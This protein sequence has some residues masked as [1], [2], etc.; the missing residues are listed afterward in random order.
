[1]VFYILANCNG[2]SQCFQAGEAGNAIISVFFDF[3]TADMIQFS[4]NKFGELLKH[5]QTMLMVMILTGHFQNILSIYLL[6]KAGHGA[7]VL[8][9]W[10]AIS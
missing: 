8:L 7:A 1:L 3:A 4:I 5:F 6:N 10:M 9:H 2:P